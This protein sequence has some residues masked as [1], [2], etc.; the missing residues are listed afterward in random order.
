MLLP[1][2]VYGDEGY[3]LGHSS[4]QLLAHRLIG[5]L[6]I[7]HNIEPLMTVA[8]RNC[9]ICIGSRLS[10][11]N[12][13]NNRPGGTYHLLVPSVYYSLYAVLKSLCN[14]LLRGLRIECLIKIGLNGEL[15]KKFKFKIGVRN[16]ICLNKHNGKIGDH[17]L[18]INI[19][20]L[21][22]E[23]I[24]TLAVNCT[25][26][27]VHNI[28]ILKESLTH[29]K[30][31]LLHLA[32]SP[33]YRLGEHLVLESLTLL[34]THCIHNLGDSL[35]SKETQKVILQ[36]DI[37]ERRTR[38]TLS[39]RTASQL[40]VNP[41][42]V[43]A[44]STYDSQT[45]RTLNLLCKF[46]ICTT[47]RHIGSNCNTTLTA[48]LRN[49]LRLSCVLLGIKHIMLYA[50]QF[51]HSAQQLRH[52]HRS[53]THKHRTSLLLKLHNLLYYGIILI[54]LGLVNLVILILSYNRFVGR[55]GNNLQL[56]DR[57]ELTRLCLGC[58]CHTRKFMIHSEV[59]LQS[60]GCKGLGCRL[61]L[62]ILL[63]LNCLM[64]TL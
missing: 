53:S 2:V 51:E 23:R 31:N 11:V 28:V 64:K 16:I 19:Y 49:N 26:L 58:T 10:L 17:I 61:H 6:Q 59:V 20:P 29:T 22:K 46:D 45:A 34:Q 15:L 62:Y 30:V 21:S 47:T 33:L 60:N 37:E 32:L 48:C 12:L 54:L 36:R 44:R 7:Y 57:P 3:C 8:N 39:S 13:L 4:W 1:V 14:L 50:A 5:L 27:G 52:L 55:D 41:S 43:V 56:V 35:C 42:A 24:L 38:V 25:S 40:A 63:C 9:N 18:Y